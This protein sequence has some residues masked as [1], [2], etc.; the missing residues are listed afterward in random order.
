VTSTRFMLCVRRRL[1]CV[2]RALV[3]A[4]ISENHI[5]K[6]LAVE[7]Y[8]AAMLIVARTSA[9]NSSIKVSFLLRS[10]CQ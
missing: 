2:L 7:A 6:S 1:R 5:R 4:S 8:S 3:R 9:R 10:T